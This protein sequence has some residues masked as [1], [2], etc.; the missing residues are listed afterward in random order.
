MPPAPSN[1]EINIISRIW[2][3]SIKPFHSLRLGTQNPTS[4][5]ELST[6]TSCFLIYLEHLLPFKFW[7]VCQRASSQNSRGNFPA[8]L[9]KSPH[10]YCQNFYYQKLHMSIFFLI[11]RH[12]RIILTHKLRSVFYVPYRLLHI[13]NFGFP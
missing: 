6:K 10:F 8:K 5:P 4:I 1:L 9:D 7:I 3:V 11:F 2:T 12:R 13:Y